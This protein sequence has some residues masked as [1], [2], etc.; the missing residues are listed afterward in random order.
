MKQIGVLLSGCGV[1]DGSEIHEA[2]LILYFLD[3]QGVN[4]LCIAPDAPQAHVINHATGEEAKESRGI[5]VESARI[6]RGDIRPISQVSAQDLDGIMIPGGFGAALNLCNY[7][8]SGRDCTVREDVSTLLLALHEQ[9]KPIGAVCIAPVL[10]ARVFGQK[11]ITVEVTIGD[12]PGVA[13]DIEA[14]GARH[15]MRLVDEVQVDRANKIATAPAYMLGGNVA[16]IG[17]GIQKAVE[18]IV[19]MA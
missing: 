9:K 3:R 14:M 12:D 1:K 15:V 11:G 10:V 17:P 7:G 19:E 5:L 4:R 13:A 2:T 6:A 18:A 16:E 8:R